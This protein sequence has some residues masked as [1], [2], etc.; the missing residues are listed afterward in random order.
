VEVEE[1]AGISLA[2]VLN[3]DKL[4]TEYSH[5]LL[6]ALSIFCK[7]GAARIQKSDLERAGQVVAGIR[8]D[9]VCANVLLDV[10]DRDGMDGLQFSELEFALQ[11]R[12]HNARLTIEPKNLAQR[13][14]TCMSDLRDST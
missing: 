13:L 7:G 3:L 8:L 2:D 9:S 10:F 4:L 12:S 11:Q 5:D 1:V 14:Q 6:Y